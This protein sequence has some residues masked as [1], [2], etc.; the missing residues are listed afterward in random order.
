M[1]RDSSHG[2]DAVFNG[3]HTP[4]VAVARFSKSVIYLKKLFTF[5]L[6]ICILKIYLLI[7]PGPSEI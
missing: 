7:L 5:Y 2:K 1:L 6:K 3:K 4:S